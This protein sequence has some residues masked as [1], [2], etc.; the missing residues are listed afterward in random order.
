MAPPTKA[1]LARHANLGGIGRAVQKGVRS[2]LEVVTPQKKR[3]TTGE[4]KETVRIPPHVI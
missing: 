3:G 2:A 1:T 4:I